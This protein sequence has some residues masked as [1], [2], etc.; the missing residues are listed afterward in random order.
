MDANQSIFGSRRDEL[1]EGLVVRRPA[2][3]ISGAVLLHGANVYQ[4]GSEHLGPA[5]GDREKVRVAERDVGDGHLRANLRPGRGHRQRGIGERRTANLAER[6]VAHHQAAL[7]SKAVAD[8]RERSLLASLGALSVGDMQ[9]GN[10]FRAFFAH[11]ER[12]A[13]GRIHAS[14]ESDYGINRAG[15]K[16]IFPISGPTARRYTPFSCGSQMNL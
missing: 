12:G 7:D 11:G 6:L 4:R 1:V 2:V 10:V 5:H 16:L 14:G 8:F 13:N 9:G 3:R 15:H